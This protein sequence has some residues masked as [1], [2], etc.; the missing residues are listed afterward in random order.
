VGLIWLYF[1][2]AGKTYKKRAIQA[3]ALAVALAL[4]GTL[5]VSHVAPHWTSE[6]RSNLATIS[7]PGGI[8]EP[9]PTS[10]GVGSPD[11]I[12]DLQTVAS[13]FHDD[14]RIYNPIT[15]VVCGTILL[16]WLIVVL[17]SRPSRDENAFFAIVSVAALSMLVTYHRSYDAKLLLLS[18]PACTMLWAEGG[19]IA[20]MALLIG[21]GG[22]IFT[23]D[24]PLAVLMHLTRH[25]YSP[26][27]GLAG[28]TAVALLTRPAPLILLV[29]AIFYLLVYLRRTLDKSSARA[30][31]DPLEH[32]GAS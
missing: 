11:M 31:C 18:I 21:V 8:N 3:G 2:L 16:A 32:L 1:L 20:W 6:L 28:K 26:A 12:I 30:Y 15:Y 4:V 25:L 17:R 22:V 29:T 14:P 23:A 27:A 10:I 13:V 9:G 24:L 5:W 7:A 19:A